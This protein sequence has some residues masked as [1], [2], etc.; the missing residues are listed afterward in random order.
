MSKLLDAFYYV[1]EANTKELEKGVEQSEKKT[2]ELDKAMDGADKTASKL[3]LNFKTVITGMAG[4]LAG[5]VAVGSMRQTIQETMEYGAALADASDRL[6]IGVEDLEAWQGAVVRA[7]G[8]VSSFTTSLESVAKGLGEF[9][10]AGSGPIADVGK[11][12]GLSLKHANGVMKT[13]T[14]LLPDIAQ[15]LHKL[16]SAQRADVAA[17]LGLDQATLGLLSQGKMAVDEIIK[18]QKELGSVTQAEAAQARELRMQMSDTNRVFSGISRNIMQAFIPSL[19][20]ILRGMERIGS[21]T[22]KNADLVKGFFVG[23]AGVLTVMYLPAILKAV[24]A[25]YALLAPYLLIIA[26]VALVGAAFALAYEDLVI[27]FEGGDSLTGRMI[28]KFKTWLAQY[29]ELEAAITS[30]WSAFKI[31]GDYAVATLKLIAGLAS[32]DVVGAFRDFD[33]A[34]GEIFAKIRTEFPAIGAAFDTAAAIAIKAG[35]AIMAV[36]KGLVDFIKDALALATSGVKV[37]TNA[38]STVKGWFGG[39]DTKDAPDAPFGSEVPTAP[40]WSPGKD[41]QSAKNAIASAN[42]APT[43]TMTSSSISNQV[44][45]GNTRTTSVDVGGVVVNT[46]ASNG[47]EVAAAVNQTLSDQMKEAIDQFDDGVDR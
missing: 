21:W 47:E 15:G 39:D 7:G 5:L 29:P 13:A 2:K 10:R 8:D 23:V 3:G 18:K 27:F 1:F 37:V 35:N 34:M 45:G 17:K 33:K 28:E 46:Q 19:T 40:N 31:L 24:A 42:S 16:S 41:L 22:V 44:M 36:W 38:A 12:L 6:G 43:N 14:E 30:V 4:A 20:S 32:G 11:T 26:A 25:T 9:K